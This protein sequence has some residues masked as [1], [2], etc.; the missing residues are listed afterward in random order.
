MEPNTDKSNHNCLLPTQLISQL[1]LLL[2]RRFEHFC[3]IMPKQ[4]WACVIFFGKISYVCRGRDTKPARASQSENPL[5][6]SFLSDIIPFCSSL[7]EDKYGKRI[8]VII[9]HTSRWQSRKTPVAR[10]CYVYVSGPV[11][12]CSFLLSLLLFSFTTHSVSKM[13]AGVLVSCLETYN[14]KDQLLC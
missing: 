5:F 4:H 13:N 9:T 10:T 7:W 14:E 8:V 6:P 3:F 11:C 12:S 1:R 2:Y